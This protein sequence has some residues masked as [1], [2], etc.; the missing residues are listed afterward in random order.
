MSDR[1]PRY[2]RVARDDDQGAWDWKCAACDRESD[3]WYPDQAFAYRSGDYHARSACPAIEAAMGRDHYKRTLRSCEAAYADA[4]ANLRLQRDEAR[5][6]RDELA[7]EVV[8]LREALDEKQAICA[9][10]TRERGHT[11]KRLGKRLRDL[12]ARDQEIKTLRADLE[13]ARATIYLL[14]GE[15]IQS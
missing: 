7:D 6:R 9:Q 14:L 10:L 5:E 13:R 4:V 12:D 15:A 2:V 11:L 3:R 8:T 1:L